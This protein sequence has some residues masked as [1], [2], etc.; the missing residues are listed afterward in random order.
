M[1]LS[2]VFIISGG[3]SSFVIGLR[4]DRAEIFRR[5]EDVNSVFEVFST[6]TTVFETV[7]DSLYTQVFDNLYYDTMYDTDKDVKNKLSNYEQLVDELKKN[8]LELD[9]LCDNVYY[10]DATVNS[11]CNN[12]RNI[13]EQVVNY[14]V[15]DINL[16]NSNIK[17]YNE[18]QESLNTLLRL[19]EYSTR[20]N[21][22]DYNGDG[23]YD[24]KEE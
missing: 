17:K 23:Q 5:V 20:R 7:R 11:R 18:Y 16:Y 15:S 14:F 8:T 10:P 4:E 19:R 13:Y 3:V 2:F 6:N 21:Y 9:A 24:G 1:T 12:Y 22:I